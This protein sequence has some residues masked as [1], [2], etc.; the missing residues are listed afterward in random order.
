MTSD[1]ISRKY[2]CALVT[3]ASSGLGEEYARQLVDSCEYMIIVARRGDLLQKLADELAI[4]SPDTG[5]HC[6]S[7]DLTL[8]DDRNGLLKMCEAM[9]LRPDLLVNNAGMGDYGDFVS[10]DWPK[11]DAMLQVNV[12]ALTHLCHSFLPGMLANGEGGGAIINVSSLASTLPIPDFAVYA[13]SKAY[14]SSFSEALRIELREFGISVIAVCP[15]PVR[16]NFGKIAMR[17]KDGDSLPARDGF[18]VTA[19]KV[20]SDSIAALHADCARVYPGW[21][22]ALLAA[23]ISI[24][25]MVLIRPLVTSRRGKL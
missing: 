21:K 1:Q 9:S 4:T 10:A 5:V 14:V 24:L 23:G 8:E 19:Q 11:L 22:V 7:A 15:G 16:T 6:L 3:G 25:P 17:V 12:T 2:R 13:A 20:V 18:Y